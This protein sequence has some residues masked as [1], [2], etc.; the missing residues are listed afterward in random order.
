MGLCHPK[1]GPALTG[2]Q[3]DPRVQALIRLDPGII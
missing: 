2:T 1:P 3:L